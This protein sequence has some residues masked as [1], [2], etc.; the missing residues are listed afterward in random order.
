M[1]YVLIHLV[2]G[3][4]VDYFFDSTQRPIYDPIY[5]NFSRFVPISM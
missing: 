1:G 3:Q 5:L 4:D 2:E